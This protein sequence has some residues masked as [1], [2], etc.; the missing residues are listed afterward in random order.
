MSDPDGRACYV[1]L[2][3][4]RHDAAVADLAQWRGASDRLLRNGSALKR[5]LDPDRYSAGDRAHVRARDLAGL[6]RLLEQPRGDDRLRQRLHQARRDTLA[7]LAAWGLIP[8][9][10]IPE[11]LALVEQSSGRD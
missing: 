8:P 10:R 11:L 5:P 9:G 4:F 1:A 6:G 7:Q 3:E 2:L